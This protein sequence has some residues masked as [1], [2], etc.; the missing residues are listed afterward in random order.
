LLSDAGEQHLLPDFVAVPLGALEAPGAAAGVG[1]VLPEGAHL[2]AHQVV[3]A[4]R[5]QLAH[6]RDVVVDTPETLY[7][8]NGV[9]FA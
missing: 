7:G 3:A 2:V 1:L 5:P 4:R 9:N 8:V 6:A